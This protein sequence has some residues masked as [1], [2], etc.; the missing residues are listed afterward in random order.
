MLNKKQYKNSLLL[1][2]TPNLNWISAQ[3]KVYFFM[4]VLWLWEI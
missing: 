1:T 2:F 3:N 4:V